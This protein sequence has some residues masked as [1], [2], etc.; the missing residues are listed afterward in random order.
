MQQFEP[1]TSLD[2]MKS[3]LKKRMFLNSVNPGIMVNGNE[4]Y[5]VNVAA[6]NDASC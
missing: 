6:C 4:I 5:D 1:I 2:Y 3:S